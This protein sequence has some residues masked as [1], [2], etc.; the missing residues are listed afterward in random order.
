MKKKFNVIRSVFYNG[1]G[2][3]LGD[4]NNDGLIDIFMTSNMG[5]ISFIE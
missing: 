4:I 3:A 5:K 1:G 2:V